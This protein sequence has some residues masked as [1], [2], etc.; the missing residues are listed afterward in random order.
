MFIYDRMTEDQFTN[1]FLKSE[2]RR[3]Q[4]SRPALRRLFDWYEEQAE[5]LQKPVEFCMIAIC[6]EWTE[7]DAEELGENFGLYPVGT[8]PNE[9]RSLSE[10]YE[11][12]T[13][14]F[15]ED[16]WLYVLPV[17]HYGEPTTYLVHESCGCKSRHPIA[18]QEPADVNFQQATGN[19][20][21][22]TIRHASN[23]G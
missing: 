3:E 7:M 15:A 12:L 4:F 23:N 10:Q 6:C 14:E 18:G 17:E 8:V 2:L 22:E 16:M 9:K 11:E 13:Q 19:R 21:Q 20:Q 1:A 5:E